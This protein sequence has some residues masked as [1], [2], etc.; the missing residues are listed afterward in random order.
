MGIPLSPKYITIKVHGPFWARGLGLRLRGGLKGLRASGFGLCFKEPKTYFF[1]IAYSY[2]APYRVL[3]QTR[4]P[5]TEV[6]LWVLEVRVRTK[7]GARTEGV[8]MLILRVLH[9]DSNPKP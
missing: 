6:G 4:E 5:T 8:G 3:T 9:R 1:E 2:E 7:G